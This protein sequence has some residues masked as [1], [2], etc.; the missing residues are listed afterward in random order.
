MGKHKDF[1]ELVVVSNDE[2]KVAFGKSIT[3]LRGI[4][5]EGDVV[6][7]RDFSG[8]KDTFDKLVEGG[9]IV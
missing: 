2:K 4:L 9:Y 1:V 7:P 8:G 6:S 5:S 3:S